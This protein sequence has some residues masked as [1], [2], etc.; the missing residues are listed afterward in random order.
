VRAG[1]GEELSRSK[2]LEEPEGLFPLN[3]EETPV[4]VDGVVTYVPFTPPGFDGDIVFGGND[5]RLQGIRI[6]S[7]F[8]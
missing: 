5:E 1:E 8:S 2:R 6:R 7:D 4:H 3:K